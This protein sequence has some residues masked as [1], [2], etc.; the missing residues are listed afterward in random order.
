MCGDLWLALHGHSSQQLLAD[1]SQDKQP[2]LLSFGTD[3]KLTEALLTSGF[4][5]SSASEPS[6][7]VTNPHTGLFLRSRSAAQN[8]SG[9]GST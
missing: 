5:C 8:S 2:C 4:R 1:P 6:S 7:G 9:Q 3:L